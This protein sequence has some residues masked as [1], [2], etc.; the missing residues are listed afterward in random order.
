MASCQRQ[1]HASLPVPSSLSPQP[2]QR[3]GA[4][5]W[6]LGP[7]DAAASLPSG[8]LPYSIHWSQEG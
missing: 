6:A 3:D 1:R 5:F 7:D 4:R 8:H 2:R